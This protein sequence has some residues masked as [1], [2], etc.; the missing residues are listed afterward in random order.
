MCFKTIAL[1]RWKAIR[2]R[3]NKVKMVRSWF[4]IW[5]WK[6]YKTLTSQGSAGRL[7]C[8]NCNNNTMFEVW[9]LANTVE[10]NLFYLLWA[11]VIKIDKKLYLICLNCK[12]GYEISEK[13]RIDLKERTILL[14]EMIKILKRCKS[15]EEKMSTPPGM[16]DL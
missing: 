12:I 2:L 16:Y 5:H 4:G 11:P 15:P 14:P 7:Q 9:E 13:D 10:F 1:S 3:D 6:D 8:E